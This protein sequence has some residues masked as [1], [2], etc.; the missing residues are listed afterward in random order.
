MEA[1][2]F[3]VSIIAWLG[4][5]VDVS[6]G[7]IIT[8]GFAWI[9]IAAAAMHTCNDTE[10]GIFSRCHCSTMMLLGHARR[11]VTLC[12]KAREVFPGRAH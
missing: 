9:C 6:K 2:D 7:C 8:I 4:L 3:V 11:R 5:L 1:H 10:S 12:C